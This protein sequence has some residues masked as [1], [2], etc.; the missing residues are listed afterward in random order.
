[1]L[2]W[3]DIAVQS[4]TVARRLVHQGEERSS[5]SR[6]YYAAYSMMTARL[7]G[8]GLKSFGGRG[9]PS[10]AQLPRLVKETMTGLNPAARREASQAIRR[11]YKYRVIADYLPG[12]LLDEGSRREALRDLLL[13]ERANGGSR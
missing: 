8:Q 1:M 9:N 13:I 12:N 7:W 6:A 10:H 11:L 2:S 3:N 5:V 4:A